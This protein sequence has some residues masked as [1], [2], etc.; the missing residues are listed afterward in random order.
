[1]IEEELMSF[2]I[3]KMPPH[4]LCQFINLSLLKFY[5]VFGFKIESVFF[6]SHP[7]SSDL[8]I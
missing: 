1:V 8:V 7:N 4:I 5:G 3:N 6:S 2:L